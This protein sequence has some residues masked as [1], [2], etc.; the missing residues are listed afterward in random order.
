VTTLEEDVFS[1]LKLN[2]KEK[3]EEEEEEDIDSNKQMI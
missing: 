2:S 1:H 3:E